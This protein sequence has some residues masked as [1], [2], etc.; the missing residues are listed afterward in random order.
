[1]ACS[2]PLPNIY[3]GIE[4]KAQLIELCKSLDSLVH[5][6]NIQG[7]IAFV[8]FPSWLPLALS[9]NGGL[10]V[11]DCLDHIAGFNNVSGYVVEQEYML[12]EQADIVVTTSAYLHDFVAKRRE[13]EIIRNAA[14]VE[15]FSK[16]PAKLAI[17]KVKPIVGYFGAIS[18]WFNIELVEFCALENPDLD[19]VLIGRVDDNIGLRSSPSLPN[20]KFYGEQPYELL[21]SYLYSFD[22][23]IIPFKMVE[24]IKATNPVKVYEYL[25]SGK[26]VVSTDMPEVRQAMSAYVYI[27]QDS[28]EF[29]A[30]IKAAL[31]EHDQAL[32]SARINWARQQSWDIRALDYLNLFKGASK[33]VSIIVLCYNSIEYTKACLGSV[34]KF[35]YYDNYEIICVDN[36]STDGTAE[37]LD[38]FK[39]NKNNVIVIHNNENLGFSGGNNVGISMASGDFIIL[40]NNDTYVTSG[41]VRDLVRPMIRDNTIGMTGPLTNNIGNEQKIKIGYRNMEEMSVA[42]SDFIRQRKRKIFYTYNLAFFCVAIRREVISEVGLLDDQYERGFF[43]DDDY[44]RRVVSAGFKLAIVDDVF[45]HH[46]LSASFD[47]LGIE[48]KQRLMKVNMERYEAKWG[49]WVPHKYRNEIGFG[50]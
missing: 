47:Q 28:Q 33:K 48:E 42:A 50:E 27:A 49:K 23:C 26:P 10:L 3:N 43:E 16:A 19:F 2:S 31:N 22:V 24:L 34:L 18:E 38:D 5:K 17:D 12:I 9:L 30:C 37:Y 6:L 40:L 14:E 11:H 46:H 8:Q 32:S 21:T 29:S 1:M 41:W 7:P 36:C 4:V 13:N 20:I 35:T 25:S 39:K 44:C 45:V 15:Y